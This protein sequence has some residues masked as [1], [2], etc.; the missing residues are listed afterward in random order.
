VGEG[1]CAAVAAAPA[2]VDGLGRLGGLEGMAAE[3]GAAKV[4][5]EPGRADRGVYRGLRS[6]FSISRERAKEL[7]VPIDCAMRRSGLRWG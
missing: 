6:L 2:A 1:G 4:A 3:E 5:A 7:S